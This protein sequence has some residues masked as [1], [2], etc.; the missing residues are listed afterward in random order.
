[1][2]MKAL[3]IYIFAACLVGCSMREI[4]IKG[5]GNPEISNYIEWSS[6]I[7]SIRTK[8]YITPIYEITLSKKTNDIITRYE[9]DVIYQYGQEFHFA[10]EKSFIWDKNSLNLLELNSKGSTTIREELQPMKREEL[11]E[12]EGV[13]IFTEPDGEV[14]TGI[15]KKISFIK[16]RVADTNFE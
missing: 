2:K 4:V 10:D 11:I 13:F 16:T 9:F 7:L 8:E 5:V 14:L 6:Q 12:R 1:M 15:K 3:Y